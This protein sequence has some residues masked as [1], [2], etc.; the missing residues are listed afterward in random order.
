MAW[1]SIREYIQI[2]AVDYVSC[3]ELKQHTSWFGEECSDFL[4]QRSTVITGSELS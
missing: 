2:S 4:D 3:Y 1:E